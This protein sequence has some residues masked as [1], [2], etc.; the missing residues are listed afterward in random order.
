MSR[1]ARRRAG[2]EESVAAPL[3]VAE[4]PTVYR[5]PLVVDSNILGAIVFI[6][7]ECALAQ[8]RIA[9][10]ELHAPT[11]L[12]DEIANIALKKSRIAGRD[13]A[14]P[15]LESYGVFPLQ[16]HSVVPVA[17]AALAR[18]YELTAYD[19]AY[20]WLAEHLKAPL[21]TFDR[22]LGGAAQRHLSAL[23]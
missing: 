8:Q 2:A 17:V 13:V 19:A 6:E 9:G 3:Y 7:A 14:T 21:A 22:R 16:L 12:D 11:L 10:C 18:R 1:G 5:L 15:A 23:E 4:P 20:L